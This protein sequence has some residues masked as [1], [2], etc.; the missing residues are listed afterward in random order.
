[1]L[2]RQRFGDGDRFIDTER[3]LPAGDSDPV[4]SENFLPLMFVYIH[5]AFSRFADAIYCPNDS[6][7]I[8]TAPADS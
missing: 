5:A 7:Q 1:M 4:G 3:H 2:C 8:V 6:H